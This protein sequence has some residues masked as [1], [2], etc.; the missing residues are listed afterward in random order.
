[1]LKQY[2]TLQQNQKQKLSRVD[3]PVMSAS[4]GTGFCSTDRK[5]LS[6]I[7]AILTSAK[8]KVIHNTEQERK[9]PLRRSDMWLWVSQTRSELSDDVTRACSHGRLRYRV[10]SG[11][12]GDENLKMR[13]DF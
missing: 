7:L 3:P 4:C 8:K 6:M 12:Q 5:S 13:C 9:W 2:K 11:E 1:M 10:Q